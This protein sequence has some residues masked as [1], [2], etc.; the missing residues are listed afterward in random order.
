MFPCPDWY[1]LPIE[2]ILK[3]G[4]LSADERQTYW[5]SRPSLQVLKGEVC[6][7]S[8]RTLFI[9]GIMFADSPRRVW[10][11]LDSF[12]R[13]LISSRDRRVSA[14][15]ETKRLHKLPPLNKAFSATKRV[16]FIA[17]TIPLR[18]WGIWKCFLVFFQCHLKAFKTIY[19]KL[20]FQWSY[21]IAPQ[22]EQDL[23]SVPWDGFSPFGQFF[24]A[25]WKHA[26]VNQVD[27]CSSKFCLTVCC[28]RAQNGK[29][30]SGYK[31]HGGT[32]ATQLRSRRS[33]VRFK[34]CKTTPC[35]R[36]RRTSKMP[37]TSRRMVVAVNIKTFKVKRNEA[38]MESTNNRWEPG[39]AH[40]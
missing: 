22:S 34:A 31:C 25:I 6:F 32:A 4:Y 33:V 26:S 7:S 28:N 23:Y 37:R 19:N 36:Q 11:H 16:I 12:R 2:I 24:C 39:F 14:L 18:V 27:V 20:P 5:N 10:S 9:A 29:S 38:A 13:K 40:L 8:T 1:L 3:L 30:C 21:C 35:R 15:W 17:A